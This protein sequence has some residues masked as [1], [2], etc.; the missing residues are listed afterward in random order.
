MREVRCGGG[1]DTGGVLTI[2]VRSRGRRRSCHQG[3]QSGQGGG[4]RGLGR[5]EN[6]F[7]HVLV[8][9]NL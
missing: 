6:Q 2:P 9:A 3:F 8:E 7:V 1:D 4:K 5:R